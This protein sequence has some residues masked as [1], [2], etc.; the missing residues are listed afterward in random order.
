[1]LNR[2]FRGSHTLVWSRLQM[3]GG[4]LLFAVNEAGIAP[5]LNAIGLGRW[6]PIG[7]LAMGVITEGLRRYKAE[8][9]KKKTV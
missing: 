7:I 6:A 2:W 9:L 4:I 3:L 1:M 5:V 8:D